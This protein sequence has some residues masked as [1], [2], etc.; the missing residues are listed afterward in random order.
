MHFVGLDIRL[1][2]MVWMAAQGL[3]WV[4]QPW[5]PA[6]P[7]AALPQVLLCLVFAFSYSAW[8]FDP[9]VTSL[10]AGK[11]RLC[12]CLHEGSTFVRAGGK[13]NLAEVDLKVPKLSALFP[14]A[15]QGVGLSLCAPGA[16]GS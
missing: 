2:L 12:K 7:C 11:T 8:L 4:W 13:R 14:A 6:G 5:I 1:E 3:H 10:M 15:A 16:G 9:S